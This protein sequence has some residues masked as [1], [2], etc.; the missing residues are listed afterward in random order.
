MSLLP[1]IGTYCV[2]THAY[3]PVSTMLQDNV[4][5]LSNLLLTGYQ[6]KDTKDTDRVYGRVTRCSISSFVKAGLWPR[7]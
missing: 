6:R 1:H 5:Q 3:R 2:C 4:M 7:S